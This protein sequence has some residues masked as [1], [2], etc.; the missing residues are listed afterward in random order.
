MLYYE[1][2]LFGVAIEI[3]YCVKTQ[4]QLNVIVWIVL[5]IVFRKPT[6]DGE[7][8]NIYIQ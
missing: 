5:Q 3:L 1:V 8:I 7:K 6:K 2:P 4:T